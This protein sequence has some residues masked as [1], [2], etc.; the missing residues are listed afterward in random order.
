M[1]RFEKVFVWVTLLSGMILTVF[2]VTLA[3]IGAQIVFDQ[4]V[5]ITRTDCFVAGALGFLV[6]DKYASWR[7]KELARMKEAAHE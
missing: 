5:T 2:F 7:L 3:W 1:K 4:S 6:F